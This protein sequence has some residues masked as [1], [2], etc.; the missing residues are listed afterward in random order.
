MNPMYYLRWLASRQVRQAAEVRRHALKLLKGQCDLLPAEAVR[1]MEAAI[2][3]LARALA[4]GA[5]LKTLVQAVQ[6]VETTAS[7]RLKPYPHASMRENLEVILVA[8]AVALAIRTFF[9][10]PFKIPTGSMQPTLFGITVENLLET[11]EATVPTGL[12]RWLHSWGLGIRYIHVVAEAD[13]Q[14][15]A[16]EPPK[17]LFPFIT[18]QRFQIGNTVQ[19]IW[20]PPSTLPNRDGVPP[21]LLLFAH[22]GVTPEK[23]Y[24]KGD[25][26]LKLKVASGDH[27]FVDR[28]SYN[29]R[30]PTRGE[31]IVFETRGIQQLP[32]DQFYIKRLLGLGPERL[33]IGEDR[34]VTANGER[35]DATSKGFENVYSF[36]PADPPRESRFSGHV[37]YPGYPYE[38]DIRPNHFAVL[39][40]N[41]LNSLDSRMWGDF[42]RTN[43]IGKYCFVYWPFTT[44]FGMAAR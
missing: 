35:L 23:T 42:S 33:V 25:T 4:R 6:E 39:G 2:G 5:D 14:I 31:I 26:I 44:R 21:H 19:T 11:P 16:V 28:V 1:A 7:N 27:L 17:Q 29:F 32:Q 24:H 9:L 15:T 34:H 18:R 41:T 36:N 10:Q 12:R 3:G 22:G 40:D 8:I 38:L 20:F 30:H 37:R 43:V 13:G